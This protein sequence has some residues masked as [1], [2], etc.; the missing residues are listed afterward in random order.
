MY[1]TYYAHTPYLGSGELPAVQPF[2][3]NFKQKRDNKR[4][5]AYIYLCEKS[6][7]FLSV[8]QLQY[9]LSNNNFI[10]FM[11]FQSS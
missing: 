3:F 4:Y 5:I 2:N 8:N 6:A 7:I 10:A 11:I 1:F 9:M